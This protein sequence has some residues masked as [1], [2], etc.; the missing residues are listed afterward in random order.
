M[1]R[2]ARSVDP[3]LNAK[4]LLDAMRKMYHQE[5]IMCGWC[6]PPEDANKSGTAEK[7]VNEGPNKQK[8]E[9][10]GKDIAE[11]KDRNEEA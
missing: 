9:E 5:C 4:G 2:L 11:G 10:C 6:K 1:E 3:C 8:K 7:A